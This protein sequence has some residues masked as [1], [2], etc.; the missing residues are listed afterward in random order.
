M[1][2]AFA[3]LIFTILLLM[4]KPHAVSA[5][6]RPLEIISVTSSSFTPCDE[7]LLV[8]IT[9]T[10]D[11][12]MIPTVTVY[13]TYFLNERAVGWRISPAQLTSASFGASAF[14]ATVPNEAYHESLPLNTRIIFYVEARDGLGNIALTCNE[15]DRWNAGAVEGKYTFALI[16]P[17]RPTIRNVTRETPSPTSRD[18]VVILANVTD[19]GAGIDKA[20][21]IF[22]I[23]GGKTWNSVLMN[24]SRGI[25]KAEI[26]AQEK[27]TRVSYYVE[28]YDKAGNIARSLLNEYQVS[29]SLEEIQQQGLKELQFLALPILGAT[30]VVLALAI[31]F[32]KRIEK[33]YV[34]KIGAVE[35][36]HPNAM[37]LS[38][39]GTIA[40][41]G[42]L[43]I[44]LMK[45]YTFLAFMLALAT[46]VFWSL[47][48]P[49]VNSLVPIRRIRIFD[50]NPP[51]TFIAGGYMLL[52][53]GALGLFS[54]YLLDKYILGV[55]NYSV[56]YNLAIDIAR[57]ALVLLA[58]GI[59]LQIA[60]PW[61]KEIEISVEAISAD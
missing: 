42:A 18:S 3:I 56:L 60:W 50:E 59:L 25:Y 13:Y 39:I 28:A 12:N 21:L 6:Q 40:I 55:P 2:K 33:K 14:T 58:A 23:D 43:C 37:T 11:V 16:D 52:L 20:L 49:R 47:A 41:I 32:H 48:D 30:A 9:V 44:Q 34:E 38:F 54:K 22:S 46:A 17:Y 29:A 7:P 45:S 57:Y 24:F 51:A 31:F 26:P 15:K 27:G 10:H 1:R 4:L 53:M 36:R 35:C 5:E 61:L 19:R 8:D